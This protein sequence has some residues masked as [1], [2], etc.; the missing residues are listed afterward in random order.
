MKR[1]KNDSQTALSQLSEISDNWDNAAVESCWGHFKDECDYR[2]CTTLDELRDLVGRYVDY[3]NN[4]RPQWNRN[5]M[6]PAEFEKHL[7]EMTDDEYSEYIETEYGKYQKMILEAGIKA[8]KRA[9]DI[10]A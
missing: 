8:R 9:H 7:N 3:Y 1:A 4:E 2:S 10:G 5:R 6:T